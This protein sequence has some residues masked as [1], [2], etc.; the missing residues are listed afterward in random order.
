MSESLAAAAAA[1]TCTGH[2]TPIAAGAD[3]MLLYRTPFPATD[4]AVTC[5]SR[6]AAVHWPVIANS[7]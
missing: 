7:G 2:W 4:G 5:A 3:Q 1:E 6:G